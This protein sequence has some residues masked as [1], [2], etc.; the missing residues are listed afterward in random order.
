MNHSPTNSKSHQPQNEPILKSKSSC[1]KW[2]IQANIT[3][4]KMSHSLKNSQ[5]QRPKN[6]L[7][8]NSLKMNHSSSQYHHA[9]NEI[10]L[11]KVNI[12]CLK[13]NHSLKNSQ[14]HQPQNESLL[15]KAWT[16]QITSKEINKSQGKFKVISSSQTDINN[17]NGR[18]TWQ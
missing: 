9:Q 16:S 17:S 6:E 2:N 7:L 12:T 5:Y 10:F 3:C 8:I 15:S 13:M 11:N 4:L 14:Y 1:S 18:H